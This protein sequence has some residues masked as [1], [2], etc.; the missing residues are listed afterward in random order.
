MVGKQH[1]KYPDIIIL[2]FDFAGAVLRALVDFGSDFSKKN[3][4]DPN[5]VGTSEAF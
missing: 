5:L 4:G 3:V 2:T 1:R